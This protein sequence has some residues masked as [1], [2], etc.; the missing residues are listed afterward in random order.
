[1]TFIYFRKCL[2]V[3]VFKFQYVTRH[4]N[5][6]YNNAKFAT[7]KL[8]R[9]FS[10]F[11]Y[12]PGNNSPQLIWIICNIRFEA[13]MLRQKFVFTF[14]CA[15]RILNLLSILLC[16]FFFLSNGIRRF[17]LKWHML[18]IYKKLLQR[19]EMNHKLILQKSCILCTLEMTVF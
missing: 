19:T 2:Y 5:E 10:K 18:P 15:R 1:M 7:K 4:F 12:M 11:S 16:F 17:W 6:C 13:K 14:S 9:P 8:K 3:M